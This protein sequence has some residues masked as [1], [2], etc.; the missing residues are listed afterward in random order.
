MWEEASKWGGA[1][2]EVATTAL[3]VAEEGFR[4]VSL[5]NGGE[6]VGVASLS[7]VDEG[8]GT[9][10]LG[11]GYEEI[12]ALATK[13]AGYGRKAMAEIARSA[14]SRGHGIFLHAAPEAVGFYRKL[15][16]A[17]S[18]KAK[19]YFYLAASAIPQFADR[20]EAESE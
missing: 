10:F 17:R 11:R 1:R 7:D 3:D 4:I 20:W 15:G 5:Q 14:H 16:M 13:R 19:D 12:G 6:L 9:E 8:P 2:A 18:R